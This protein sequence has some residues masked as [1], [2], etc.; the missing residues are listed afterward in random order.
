MRTPAGGRFASPGFFARRLGLEGFYY[1]FY[2]FCLRMGS[3]RATVRSTKRLSIPNPISLNMEAI[4]IEPTGEMRM[5]IEQLSKIRYMD[6]PSLIRKLIDIGIEHELKD[7]AI[8][9]FRDK[10]VSLGKAAEISGISKRAMLDLLKERD[11]TLNISTRD[12]QKDFNAA[13][14]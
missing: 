5:K 10:K 11:I 8:G 9:L 3:Y 2:W 14:E 13:T 1:Y 6:T 7:Y 4:S 12:I